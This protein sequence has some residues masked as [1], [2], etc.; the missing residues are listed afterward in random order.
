MCFIHILMSKKNIV[1]TLLIALLFCT[2][3]VQYTKEASKPDSSV[4]L[5][6]YVDP[7]IGSS[8]HGHVFVGANV[9][10]GAVQLGP[11]QLSEGWDWCSGY[12][13]SDSIIIGFS[14][15]HLSGT[16]IGDLGDILVMPATGNVRPTKGKIANLADGYSSLFSHQDEI[17]KPG[18]YAV[19]LKRYNIKAELTATERV[20]FHRYTFPK[21]DDAHI[22][23]DLKEGIGWD[24]A[25]ET[26]L[27]Q[28]ND[29]TISGYRYS[30]GW[31]QDQRI[32]FAAIFSKPIQ[33]ITLYNDTIPEASKTLTG[34]RIKAIT[35]FQVKDNEQILLKVGISPVSMSNALQNIKTEI[36]HWNFERVVGEADSSWNKELNKVQIDVNDE[37]RKKIFYTSL[38]HTMIAPSIFNDHNGDYRGT[39]KQVYHDTTFTNLTTFSLWDTYR[40]THSLYTILQPERVNNMVN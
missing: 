21:S 18:F 24:N 2:A 8:F 11:T 20:G 14:H 12:H 10:F 25:T 33:S 40:S 16:G 15:T 9:P 13:Y 31:A 39:D 26:H 5:T 35:N 32:F 4:H 7:Y 34:K 23:I 6:D 22:I 3:C 29:T 27:E 28:V 38:Y 1:H 19:N 17:V 36:P 37:A 30:S